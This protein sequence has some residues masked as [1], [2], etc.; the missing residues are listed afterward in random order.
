MLRYINV[1]KTYDYFVIYQ[2]ISLQLSLSIIDNL[3]IIDKPGIYR[4]K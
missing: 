1:I 4:P 3:I 2:I